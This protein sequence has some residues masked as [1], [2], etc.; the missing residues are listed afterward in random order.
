MKDCGLRISDCG[1]RIADFKSSTR[2]SPPSEGGVAAASADGVVNQ[3]RGWSF[4]R[5]SAAK[6]FR[7]AVR[8]TTGNIEFFDTSF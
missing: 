7:G 3:P 8:R 5:N 1:F 2:S 4:F 6:L